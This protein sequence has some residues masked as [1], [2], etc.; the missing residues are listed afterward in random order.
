MYTCA[1]PLATPKQNK[2]LLMVKHPVITLKIVWATALIALMVTITACNSPALS[3][4]S[5]QPPII[6]EPKTLNY[7]DALNHALISPKARQILLSMPQEE[8]KSVF[9]PE[10]ASVSTNYISSPSIE[11]LS[12]SWH[13]V[14][15]G[16]YKLFT[17]RIKEEID[18]K[19][20]PANKNISLFLKANQDSLIS[21]S[22]SSH[23]YGTAIKYKFKNRQQQINRSLKSLR[24][25]PKTATNA[26]TMLE[27]E[28]QAA[29]LKRFQHSFTG[30]EQ[31]LKSTVLSSNNKSLALNVDFFKRI[32]DPE[33]LIMRHSLLIDTMLNNKNIRSVLPSIK[34][35][36]G[37]YYNKLWRSKFSNYSYLI[38]PKSAYGSPPLESW[39]TY[40]KKLSS[41]VNHKKASGIK[42]QE[43]LIETAIILRLRIALLEYSQR[44]EHFK[45]LKK[46]AVHQALL[47]PLQSI[48]MPNQGHNAL[49]NNMHLYSLELQTHIAYGKIIESLIRL[50]TSVD[51]NY[52]QAG[53]AN[54]LSF[55]SHTGKVYI[56]SDLNHIQNN[57]ITPH[58]KNPAISAVSKVR[59]VSLKSVLSTNQFSRI[60][61]RA[62]K[63]NDIYGIRL[64]YAKSH[65]EFTAHRLYSGLKDL[66]YRTQMKGFN[67]HYSI[68]Y[69]TYPSK[70]DAEQG[71]DRIPEFY[72]LF[73]PVIKQLPN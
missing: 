33:A 15:K 67:T 51:Y 54:A 57:K 5:H 71:L 9:L 2:T 41:E 63:N 36:T 66:P 37:L 34:K 29:E 17:T 21:A 4:S 47:T 56:S 65:A 10:R 62:I 72:Q 73:K 43:Q 49:L 58:F 42:R 14:N 59:S 24:A 11:A 60:P 40:S 19:E 26:S 69:A 6:H 1:L 12:K 61:K 20:T 35:R 38:E 44:Y 48:S 32:P 68:Y 13:N 25:Q 23:F 30:H 64:L 28:K 3:P 8:A 18:F 53:Q 50:N 7:S 46:Q 27:I 16:L 45:S 70:L 52:G 31:S 55:E 22:L 39:L